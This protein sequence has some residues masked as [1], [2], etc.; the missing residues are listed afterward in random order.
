MQRI[1]G[2]SQSDEVGT[3]LVAPIWIA[4]RLGLGVIPANKAAIFGT[5]QKPDV[6]PTV[7]HDLNG[8]LFSGISTV[9]GPIVDVDHHV[10]GRFAA[11]K[12]HRGFASHG[13][14]ARTP[15]GRVS[16]SRALQHVPRLE[17]FQTYGIRSVRLQGKILSRRWIVFRQLAGGSA[18]DHAVSPPIEVLDE[19]TVIGQR[20]GAAQLGALAEIPELGRQL[21]AVMFEI[22]E[23]DGGAIGLRTSRLGR[24]RGFIVADGVTIRLAPQTVLIATVVHETT[25]HLVAPSQCFG[26]GVI[27]VIPT[28]VFH[29][30]QSDATEDRIV[31]VRPRHGFV[32]EEAFFQMGERRAVAT[33]ILQFGTYVRERERDREIER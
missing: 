32:A 21:V 2:I 13:I 1:G 17:L 20:D 22:A 7:L 10:D 24:G 19:R 27:G 29:Q 28:R 14:T 9:K 4:V 5:Q 6:K 33:L 31:G 12:W 15:M 26:V 23:T 18:Q 25:A 8:Q 11:H 3:S 16:Y 30:G